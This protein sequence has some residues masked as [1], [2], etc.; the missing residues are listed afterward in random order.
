MVWDFWPNSARQP[1]FYVLKGSLRTYYD[2]L[3][4]QT[5]EG[6]N[7]DLLFKA[8]EEVSMQGRFPV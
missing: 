7:T 2:S 4:R 8:G 1:W 3:N 6:G 5:T